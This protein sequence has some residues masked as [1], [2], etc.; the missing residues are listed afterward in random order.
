MPDRPL[1]GMRF[2]LLGSGSRGNATL[3]EQG[4]TLIML[5]CGFSCREAERRMQRLGRNPADLSA[6]VVTHEHGDHVRGV[7]ALARKYDLQV[8]MTHGTCRKLRDDDLPD[9]RYFDGRTVLEIGDLQV[10]PFTVP[11]DA[12]EPCQVTFDNGQHRLGV[13]TDTGRI[14]PHIRACLDDAHA[15]LLECNHDVD[16]L[17]DGPYSPAL[18]RRVGGPLGHL[19]NAQAAQL[20]RQLDTSHLQHLV[21]AHLSEKNNAPDLA[22]DALAGVL[23]CEPHWIGI[24]GQ[25]EGLG[26]REIV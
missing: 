6:V 13:L 15:L 23:D 19:S 16:M 24:A 1:T 21:A 11:H 22:R 7:P 4:R 2:A 10:R 12:S 25:D 17:A 5:D 20:L 14:T 8:W 26:W 18:K 3:V 9:I